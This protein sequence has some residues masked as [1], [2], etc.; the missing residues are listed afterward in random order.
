MFIIPI[1]ELDKILNDH[2][3]SGDAETQST[4]DHAELQEQP[5]TDGVDEE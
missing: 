1:Q 3:G 4:N 2:F 5:K